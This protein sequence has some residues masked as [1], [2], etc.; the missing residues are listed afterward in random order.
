MNIKLGSG[1]A[2][3]YFTSSL[4]GLRRKEMKLT[5]DDIPIFSERMSPSHQHGRGDTDTPKNLFRVYCT[6]PSGV[7]PVVVEI[8]KP[9]GQ[10]KRSLMKKN[11][12]HFVCH[13]SNANR[14]L[15]KAPFVLVV[16]VVREKRQS[17]SYVCIIRVHNMIG[18]LEQNET[19]TISFPF[20]FHFQEE[21]KIPSVVEYIIYILDKA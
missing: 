15:I 1:A 6:F 16:A 12:S 14:R 8:P 17:F 13:I 3:E 21:E 19:S 18:W 4:E 9:W 11:R 10:M 5:T 7:I 2:V 20:H